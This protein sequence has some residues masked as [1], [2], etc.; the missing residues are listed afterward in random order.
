MNELPKKK[1]LSVDLPLELLN[2]VKKL[3]IDRNCTTTKWI[4]RAIVQQMKRDLGYLEDK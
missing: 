1:R 4:M 2:E 3:A